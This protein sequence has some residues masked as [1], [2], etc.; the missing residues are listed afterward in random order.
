MLCRHCLQP[1]PL[2]NISKEQQQMLFKGTRSRI[3]ATIESIQDAFR[4][5]VVTLQ[6]QTLA[7]ENN[8]ATVAANTAEQTLLRSKLDALVDHAAYLVNAKRQELQRA[9]H[10]VA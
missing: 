9:G 7:V 2:N 5:L 4:L 3:K 10:K 6:T 8:T 1:H